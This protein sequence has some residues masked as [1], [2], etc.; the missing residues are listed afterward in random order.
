MCVH[1]LIKL[2]APAKHD[3]ILYGEYDNIKNGKYISIRMKNYQR[4]KYGIYYFYLKKKITSNS[5][6]LIFFNYGYGIY[7]MYFQ[8]K[9]KLTSN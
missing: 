5:I 1:S 6:I 7:N 4:G 2:E 8:Q 9:K 3:L